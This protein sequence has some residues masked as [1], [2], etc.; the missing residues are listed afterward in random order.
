M[1]IGMAPWLLA[2]LTAGWFGW[3]ARRE[4]RNLA[5][6]AVGGFAFGLVTSTLVLGLGQASSIPFSDHE[7]KVD[8]IEWTVAA[9]VLIA[10]AGWL[11]TA[12]LHR[13]HLTVWRKFKP[14][15]DSTDLTS[16][17]SRPAAASSKQTAG[18][19]QF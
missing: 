12:S 19:T 3:M 2:L 14:G 11:L 16:A 13:H 8:Q 5:L 7:R 1:E 4:E 17:E 18:R 9:V 10:V 15:A 6:W